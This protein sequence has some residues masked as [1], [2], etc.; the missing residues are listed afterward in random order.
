M[1][2]RTLL[3]LALALAAGPAPAEPME[4]EIPGVTAELVELRQAGGVLRLAVRYAN[5]GDREASPSRFSVGKIALVDVKSKQKHF[6]IK[7]ANG[8]YIGGPIGDAIDGGRVAVAIPPGM[9]SIA[10]AYFEPLPSGSVVSVEMPQMFPFEDVPVTEGPGTLLAADSARSTPY[11]ALA[12]LAA[13]KRSDQ[14]LKVR[15][16]LGAEPGGAVDLRSPYFEYRGVYLFDPASKRKYPLL[17][18]T[19]GLFQAQPL[20]VHS[21]GGS[22]IP[23]WSQNILMSLTFQAPPDDVQS[24][25]LVLPDFLPMESIA[26]EG[27]GGAAAGG[28]AAGGRT[29]GLEGALKELQAEVTPQEI[30]IDLSSDVLFDFDQSELKPAAEERLGHLLTVVHSRPGAQISIAGHTDV[31]GDD[32]YNQTLSERRAGSVRSWLTA[33]GVEG[34][35][36]TATGAGESRP[37]RAGNTEEDHQANR[38][39]EIRIRN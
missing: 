5:A 18:D 37:L 19:D 20:K 10:W 11:G 33:H 26:I 22:F 16:K 28:I 12:T 31:R 4:T 14:A 8:A 13:A 36:I 29:L 30:V 35:H 25:D 9:Q 27:L 39:V 17:K 23:D 15:L 1:T 2:K 38:R 3:M 7:D 34:S 32:A 21:D 24:V 6:P